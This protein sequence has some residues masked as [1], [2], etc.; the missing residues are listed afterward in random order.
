MKYIIPSVTPDNS[1]VPGLIPAFDGT[2]VNNA[3]T[4]RLLAALVSV[5]GDHTQDKVARQMLRNATA[6]LFDAAGRLDRLND[7]GPVPRP[8]LMGGA[9][10]V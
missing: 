10:G 2:Q 6:E 4:T 5:A 7:R 3:R 9:R 8:L 1:I